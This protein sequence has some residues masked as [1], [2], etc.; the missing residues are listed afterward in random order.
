MARVCLLRDDL[1]PSVACANECL[2][3]QR[4]CGKSLTHCI[5]CMLNETSRRINCVTVCGCTFPIQFYGFEFY[6]WELLLSFPKCYIS[7]RF[8]LRSSPRTV[9]EHSH[10][11]YGLTFSL[12]RGQKRAEVMN[13]EGRSFECGDLFDREGYTKDTK[14]RYPHH[15]CPIPGSGDTLSKEVPMLAVPLLKRRQDGPCDRD[16]PTTENIYNVIFPR[17]GVFLGHLWRRQGWFSTAITR[18]VVF[19]V[20][21]YA[22]SFVSVYFLYKLIITKSG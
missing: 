3:V 16:P 9:A 18:D 8:L 21:H 7:F 1:T 22:H 13:G 15:Q 19:S 10:R 5:R 12:P 14:R 2:H 17:R 6:H 4:L 11:I 20:F